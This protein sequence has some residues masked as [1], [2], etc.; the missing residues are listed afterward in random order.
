M[1]GTEGPARQ[2][3]AERI[4]SAPKYPHSGDSPATDPFRYWF[5]E[6]ETQSY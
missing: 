6:C 2:S 5:Q 4:L 3:R 1:T